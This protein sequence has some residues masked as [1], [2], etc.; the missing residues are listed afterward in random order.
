M[1][2][3]ALSKSGA[4]KA[5]AHAEQAAQKATDPEVGSRAYYFLGRVHTEAGRNRQAVQ[6][7]DKLTQTYPD[8]DIAQRAAG[9]RRRLKIKGSALTDLRFVA[10][11]NKE[12][13]IAAYKGKVVLIDFWATWCGPCLRDM[14]NLKKLYAA[15]QQQGF[16]IIGVSLDEDSIEGFLRD[17]KITWPQCFDGKGWQNEMAVRYGVSSIP[18]SFLVDR[19]GKV[20]ETDLRGSQL[21]RAVKQLLKE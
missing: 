18:A 20:R 5:V 11:D 8:L 16:E 4:D 13:D 1:L 15:L 9:K 17:H 2:G 14:P 3:Y 12:V 19:E 6:A 21:E 7:Y 10:L